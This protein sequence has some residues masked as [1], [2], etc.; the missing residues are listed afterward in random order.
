MVA[1]VIDHIRHLTRTLKIVPCIDTNHTSAS[2]SP[3]L[4]SSLKFRGEG[5]VV[6]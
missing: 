5:I 3:R 2:Q 4:K 1:I 6:G